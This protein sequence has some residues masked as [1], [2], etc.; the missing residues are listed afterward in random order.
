[1][2]EHLKVLAEASLAAEEAEEA[3]GAGEATRAEEALDRADAVL[4]GLREAWPQM[5]GA[6]RGVVGPSAKTVRERVEALRARLPKRRALSETAP[7]E[8]PEQ[9]T[10]PEP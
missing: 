5:A 1:M 3:L 4:A 7:V 10:E 2:S 6:E 8:D 9:E